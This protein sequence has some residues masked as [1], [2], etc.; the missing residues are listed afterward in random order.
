MARKV[1]FSSFV[2]LIKF[3]QINLEVS[4]GSLGYDNFIVIQASYCT[5]LTLFHSNKAVPFG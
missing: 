1:E 3:T 5:Q 2:H 4:F